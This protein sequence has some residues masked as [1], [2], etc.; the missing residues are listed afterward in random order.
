MK[1]SPGW[2]SA[3]L[4]RVRR[5]IVRGDDGLRLIRRKAAVRVLPSWHD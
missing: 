4:E 3:S 1:Q 2:S 5:A